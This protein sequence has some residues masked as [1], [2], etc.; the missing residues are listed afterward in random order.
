MA[1]SPTRDSRSA[2]I[3]DLVL[4][5]SKEA[6]EINIEEDPIKMLLLFVI[7]CNAFN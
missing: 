6:L 7:L 5:F 4:E 3:E 1:D 2:E